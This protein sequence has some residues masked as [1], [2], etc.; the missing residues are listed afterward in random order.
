MGDIEFKP[1]P[2]IPRLYR[3]CTVTE[4]IDGTNGCIVV[5][6]EPY[7][8]TISADVL[9]VVLGEPT[10]GGGITDHEHHVR[11]QSRSR[12]ITPDSDNFGFA[13][14]VQD[15]AH[16]L[17]R[18][19]GPG[20]HFGEWWGHGIQRGYGQTQH[21]NF[22]LFNTSRWEHPIHSE[23]I[24]GVPGLSVVPTLAEGVFSD[25]LVDKALA[26]LH[27]LGSVAAPGFPNPEGVIVYHHTSNRLFKVLLE[28]DDKP[29]G[30]G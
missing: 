8:G 2:K 10:N 25:A 1:W 13:G 19:L 29:K 16:A 18:T 23:W 17:A 27:E 5:T 11:A 28:G 9:A 4:K 12:I 22:S 3:E 21:R 26:T 24:G 7:G 6:E 14:W 20:Y 15:N 30:G